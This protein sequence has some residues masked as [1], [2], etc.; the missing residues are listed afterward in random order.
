MLL[1][2]NRNFQITDVFAIFDD[3]FELNFATTQTYPDP[4]T[5]FHVARTAGVNAMNWN[6]NESF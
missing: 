3:R 2:Q 6:H 5:I 4:N 1:I